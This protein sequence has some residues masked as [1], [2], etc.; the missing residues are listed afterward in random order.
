MNG[1]NPTCGRRAQIVHLVQM[2]PNS[3]SRWI[4][5]TYIWDGNRLAKRQYAQYR[6]KGKPAACTQ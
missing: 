5:G 4:F 3:P 2:D 1:Q 6:H